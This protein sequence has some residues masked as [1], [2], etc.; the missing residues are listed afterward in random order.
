MDHR[1]RCPHEGAYHGCLECFHDELVAERNSLRT[2]LTAAQERVRKL[3]KLCRWALDLIDLYD[4]RLAKIDGPELV[5][6]KTHLA[7]K[8]KARKALEG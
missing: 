5:Y 7:G 2:Q 1:K 4:E 8:A 6:S 3:V